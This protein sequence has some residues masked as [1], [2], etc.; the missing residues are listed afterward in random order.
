MRR[1][2]RQMP[3]GPTGVIPGQVPAPMTPAPGFA[4]TGVGPAPFPTGVPITV[5][6]V[7][8]VVHPTRYSERQSVTRYPIENVYPS[9]THNVHHNV[10]EYYCCY[11]HTESHQ[12]CN[13]T[14]NHCCPPPRRR[15]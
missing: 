13:H 5:A 6:P 1:N 7:R 8:R 11:P 15:C 3:L 12:V 4:P 9:H 10:C 2:F 14:V